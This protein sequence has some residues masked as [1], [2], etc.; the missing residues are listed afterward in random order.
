MGATSRG[1][2]LSRPLLHLCLV[3]AAVGAGA[4]GVS[5]PAN[6]FMPKSGLVQH[7]RDPHIHVPLL[8]HT[9]SAALHC[10]VQHVEVQS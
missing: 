2:N 3:E 10:A 9:S 5:P 8:K 1:T 4:A 7:V 6:W